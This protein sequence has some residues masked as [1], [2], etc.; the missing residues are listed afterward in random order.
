MSRGEGMD[1]VTI[2]RWIKNLGRQHSELVLEAVIPDLPLACLFID[3]DG[4]QMEPENAI[5]LHF[6]PR[7]MR[8][9]EI[10]FIL[11]EPEPSPFETYKGELPWPFTIDMGRRQVW[12]AMGGEPIST[13]SG[14]PRGND[15]Y[16]LDPKYHPDAIVTF[17]YTVNHRVERLTFTVGDR[18]FWFG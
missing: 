15:T 17:Q 5:E 4:L 6:D 2:E 3:D 1:A 14:S 8:F 11:H 7:T 13:Y 12:L 16:M 10:S 9:E 18:A